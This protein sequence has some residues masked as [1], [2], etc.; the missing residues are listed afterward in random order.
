MY[1]KECESFANSLTLVSKKFGF[2][3]YFLLCS[4]LLVREHISHVI[5]ANLSNLISYNTVPCVCLSHHYFY[6]SRTQYDGCYLVTMGTVTVLFIS[7]VFRV[8]IKTQVFAGLL[9]FVR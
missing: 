7:P 9:Y 6:V 1:E 5:T 8:I 4:G 3:G 2:I